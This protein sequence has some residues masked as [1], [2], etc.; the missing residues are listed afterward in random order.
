VASGSNSSLW[1]KPCAA[2]SKS[3]SPG[4]IP[5]PTTSASNTAATFSAC[6]ACPERATATERVKST[7]YR[8][9][10]GYLCAFTPN[11]H[12]ARY[13]TRTVDFFAAYVVPEDVWYI[14]PSRVVLKT[15]SH[16]LMLC[17]GRPK[18]RSDS[19]RYEIYLEAWPLL[20]TKRP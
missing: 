7:S 18:T 10:N 13:T 15:K 4:E 1:R 16:E 2:D 17:P 19:N 20:R 5:P 14:L 11:R 8:L 3:P 12:G 9:G 6:K